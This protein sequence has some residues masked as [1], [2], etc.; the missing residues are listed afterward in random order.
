MN[1][2]SLGYT[3]IFTFI[4]AFALVLPLSVANQVTL[5]LVEQNSKLVEARAILSA[6][7]EDSSGL[8]PQ[9]ILERFASLTTIDIGVEPEGGNV[10][11]PTVLYSARSAAGN[12]YAGTFSGPALWGQVEIAL[13]FDAGV[14]KLLG[15]SVISQNETPGLGGR[16][17][18]PWFGLQFKDQS[19][20]ADRLTF[21]PVTSGKQGNVEKM[22]ARVDGITGATR[23]SEGVVAL[24]NAASGFMK[25][26]AAEG[27][28]Q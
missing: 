2:N 22:D 24:V 9:K 11:V 28:L 12:R 25:Q 16:I 17:T 19:I 23:T 5:P 26:L 3:I 7:G 18:E 1:K 14:E 8:A 21:N 20:P 10:V 27:V 6:L 4:V 15:F 13:G